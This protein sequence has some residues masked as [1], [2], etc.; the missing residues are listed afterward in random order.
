MHGAKWSRSVLFNLEMMLYAV[1]VR[2]GCQLLGDLPVCPKYPSYDI[3][4]E[5][6]NDKTKWVHDFAIVFDKMLLNKVDL[7]RLVDLS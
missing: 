1:S 2:H 6:A 3:A 7:G 5:Y 4:E